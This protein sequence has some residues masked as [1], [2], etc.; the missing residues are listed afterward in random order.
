MNK[1][2][3]IMG[4]LLL[5]S[6]RTHGQTL[7]YEYRYDPA[8]NRFMTTVIAFDEDRGGMNRDG[9]VTPLTDLRPD[10]E[11]ILV[12]PN[13]TTGI[14]RIERR[15]DLP[16]GGYL[17]TDL[18]GNTIERGECHDNVLTLNLTRLSKGTYILVF[19]TRQKHINY[20]LIKQ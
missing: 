5:L 8:G 6:L 2:S 4:F 14:V 9:A 12:F 20:K 7:S 19:G 17:L 15:E 3:L 18:N 16:I 10:G 11:T 13:P 1:L